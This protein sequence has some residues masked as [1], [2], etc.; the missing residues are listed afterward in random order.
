MR[1]GY[2]P[3]DLYTDYP[4]CKKDNYYVFNKDGSGEMNEGFTK[5]NVVDPQSVSFKWAIQNETYIW[6]FGSSWRIITL[7]ESVFR[8][9]TQ[10]TL[11][12]NGE[13]MSF[14]KI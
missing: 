12:G 9:T 4:S 3:I 14:S 1:V 13:N 10:K 2:Q 11:G 5:C 6:L 8:I 7:N